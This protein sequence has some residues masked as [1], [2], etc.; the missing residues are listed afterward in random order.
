MAQIY[1]ANIRRLVCSG[2][3]IR[4]PHSLKDYPT[5]LIMHGIG[6]SCFLVQSIAV[7]LNPVWNA[8]AGLG[9]IPDITFSF[10]LIS[11]SILSLFGCVS[12]CLFGQ[13]KYTLALGVFHTISCSMLCTFVP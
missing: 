6:E 12:F 10:H 3:Q 8:T 7:V 11:Y 2:V 1:S 9:T 4:P 13:G 5:E